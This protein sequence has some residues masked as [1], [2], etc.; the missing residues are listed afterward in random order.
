VPAEKVVAHAVE[1]D[2]VDDGRD[3]ESRERCLRA[4][5]GES[6]KADASGW[7][8]D[9]DEAGENVGHAV[10][11]PGRSAEFADDGAVLAHA[12]AV[13]RFD[14]VHLRALS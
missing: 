10:S 13:F 12:E 14:D 6:E 1:I 8:Q 7:L 4:A 5:A 9:G 2:G 3:A 11:R